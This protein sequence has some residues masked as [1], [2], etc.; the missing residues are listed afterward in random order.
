MNVLEDAP[1]KNQILKASIAT[2]MLVS[3]QRDKFCPSIKRCVPHLLLT[4]ELNSLLKK[5]E[6]KTIAPQLL[7]QLQYEL[8]GYYFIN[9]EMEKLNKRFYAKGTKFIELAQVKQEE[10]WTI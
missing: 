7:E 3:P 1:K 6:A 2:N 8:K 5:E 4:G 9:S 10:L